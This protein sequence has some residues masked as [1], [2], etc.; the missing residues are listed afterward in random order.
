[1][2]ATNSRSGLKNRYHTSSLARRQIRDCGMRADDRVERNG[3]LPLVELA[4]NGMNSLGESSL[5]S[6]FHNAVNGLLARLD[7]GDLASVGRQ[8]QSRPVRHLAGHQH[9]T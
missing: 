3:W 5:N 7:C 9:M 8:E 1:M 4:S 6:C 2:N